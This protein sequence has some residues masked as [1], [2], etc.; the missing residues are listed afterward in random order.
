MAR[1]KYTSSSA[2]TQAIYDKAIPLFANSGFSGVSMRHVANAV[3]IS[4]AALYHHFPDKKTLYIRCIESAF[5]NKATGLTDALGQSGSPEQK[6]EHFIYQFTLL[7]SKDEHFRQLLQRELLD[8][9]D[10][11]L[12]TLAKDVFQTQFKAVAELAQTLAPKCDAHMMAISITGL[13]LFHL[14]T[15]PLR[16]FLPGERSEHNT[17]SFIAAHVTQLLLNGVI[18]C[19]A[20]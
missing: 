4:I 20:E 1:S 12:Q 10:A 11:R 13:V 14:E 18:K 16:Q 19:S 15:A 5:S 9:D 7:M 6:L 2:A 8:G 3:D 17:P